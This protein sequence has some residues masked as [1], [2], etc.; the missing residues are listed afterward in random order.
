M[1]YEQNVFYPMPAA[2]DYSSRQYYMSPEYHGLTREQT[3]G[4]NSYSAIAGCSNRAMA[5]NSAT[6]L[7]EQSPC[8]DRRKNRGADGRGRVRDRGRAG[9][10]Q[11]ISK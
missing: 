8:E 7:G 6:G 4:R 10:G 5:G 9:R 2:N 1:Y 11:R 3:I